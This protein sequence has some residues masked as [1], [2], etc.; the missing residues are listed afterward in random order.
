MIIHSLGDFLWKEKGTRRLKT[1]TA[2]WLSKEMCKWTAIPDEQHQGFCGFVPECNSELSHALFPLPPWMHHWWGASDTLWSPLPAPPGARRQPG[3]RAAWSS[4]CQGIPLLS[5]STE[6]GGG[7]GATVWLK[8]RIA[9]WAS[10]S[11][12]QIWGLEWNQRLSDSF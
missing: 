1:S 2:S 12:G 8:R 7:R 3:V 4:P 10:R 11:F 5:A 9:L 6:P